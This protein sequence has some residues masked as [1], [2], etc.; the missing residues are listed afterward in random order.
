MGRIARPGASRYPRAMMLPALLTTSES[1]ARLFDDDPRW[2]QVLARSAEAE[3]RFV[4]AVKSTGVFCRPPA[5]A[6]GRAASRCGSSTVPP[7]PSGPASGPA[8]AAGPMA[9]VR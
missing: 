9:P 4:Y 1:M 5:R 7:T 2:A 3:G 6:A 8:C